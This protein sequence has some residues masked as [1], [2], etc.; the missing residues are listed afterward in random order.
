MQPK[1]HEERKQ[2]SLQAI[3]F[4]LAPMLLFGL[5]VGLFFHQNDTNRSE[6]KNQLA[7][8]EARLATI[9]YIQD[10]MS[11]VFERRS[12]LEKE[13]RAGFADSLAGRNIIETDID[14]TNRQMITLLNGLESQP[15]KTDVSQVQDLLDTYRKQFN[16]LKQDHVNFKRRI[17]SDQSSNQRTLELEN[18]NLRNEINRANDEVRAL[19]RELR[20]LSRDLDGCERDLND[21]KNSSSGGGSQPVANND[22]PRF[23][24]SNKYKNVYRQMEAE[25]I[26]LIAEIDQKLKKSDS[27]RGYQ[28]KVKTEEI[29]TVLEAAQTRLKEIQENAPR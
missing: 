2:A 11:S 25:L 29:R 4:T 16:L 9:A 28:N 19:N 26:D 8:A 15:E 24:P 6:M 7:A 5:L 10:T 21:I 3:V 20:Q 27:T 22:P 18:D 12:E 13:Y 14:I 1:N 23:T 17:T